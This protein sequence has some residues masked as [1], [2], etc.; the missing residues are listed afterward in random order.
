MAY[1]ELFERVANHV[2]RQGVTVTFTRGKPLSASAIERARAKSV[3]P[4]PTSLAEFYAEVGNGLTFSWSADVDA[5]LFA[6]LAFPKFA[7]CVIESLP[8]ERSR[9]EWSDTYDFRFTKNPAMARQTA[10]KMRKWLRFHDEGNGDE[11]SLDTALD[12]APVLFNQHDWFD[13]GS[14]ENGHRLSDSLLQFY[15]EWAQVCFQF[16]RSLWWPNVFREDG[17]GVDWSSDEFREPFKLP[18]RR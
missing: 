18:V 16:P 14:G 2:R 8:T 3:I 10:L 15:T 7:D 9:I 6:N 4:I 5:A 13:G 17:P 1:L 12:P 11:F